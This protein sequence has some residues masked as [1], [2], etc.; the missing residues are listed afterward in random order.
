MRGT[1]PARD[2]AETMQHD[3]V[4]RRLPGFIDRLLTPEMALDMHRDVFRNIKPHA[5]TWR[6]IR[7]MIIGAEYEPPRPEEVPLMI[8]DW[9]Q[10]YARRWVAGEDVFEL[11]AWMHWKF[12]AIHPFEDGNGRVGR[13][14]LNMHFMRQNWPPIH[15]GP[16]EK[17]EYVE[18]L[19]AGHRNDLTP[20]R[21][22]FRASMGRSLLDLLD[23]VG[24]AD[25]A[26]QTITE[27]GKSGPYDRKYLALRASQG[28]L[29]A[30]KVKGEWKTSR[31]ALVI[32]A[33]AMGRKGEE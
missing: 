9:A 12:E 10:E 26:L 33:D 27:L 30:M 20:L 19:Q 28:A 14:L 13:L 24:T 16:P 23:Q 8:R 15:L 18:A 25:D 3:V 2:V 6:I 5:G 4:F 31:R 21:N 17:D 22:L 7:V 32:Y 29:P 1:A 11:A